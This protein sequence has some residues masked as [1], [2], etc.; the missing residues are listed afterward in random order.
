MA[1]VRNAQEIDGRRRLALHSPVD[2]RPIAEFD[3][4]DRDD[5]RN[6]VTR[7]RAAQP[8]WA[9]RDIGERAAIIG[10]AIDV[11]VARR[12]EITDTIREETGKPHAEALGVEI[13]PSCDFLNYWTKRARRDLRPHRQ[14]LHGYLRP[15]KK[16]HIQYQPLGVVAVITP[17]NAPFVLTLNPVV[18]A[19]LAGNTVVFKPSEVTPRSGE[20]VARI[21][22]EAGVPRDV[23]QALHGDGETGA[24]LVDSPVDKVCFT[25]SVGTGR[26]IAT[27]C[28]ERL[29][30]CTLELGGKDAMI[31]CADADLE[32]AAAGA[33]Y[34]SMFNTGQVCMSVERIYVIDSV[35]DEFIALVQREAAEVTC[36]AGATDMGPL[37]WDRQRDIVT[38]HVEDARTRGAR[39]L[40]GGSAVAGEGLYF[41]PTV[42]AEAN[43]DMLIMTDE[44]FGPVAAIMRVRDEDEAIRLAND[45]RYG[46]SGS[47]FTRDPATARRIAARLTTGSVVHN[48]S[49]VIYGVPEAPFG[50]RKDSG[51]GH[52]NGVHA[53]R[54]FTHA[55][56]V[57]ITR[58]RPSRESIWYPYT[59]KTIR[60]LDGLIRY[61]FGNKLL[62]RLLS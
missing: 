28:A 12:A 9:A 26:K 53:L 57:L 46:L 20:W 10:R 55:Q 50:G 8:D 40:V 59:D 29:L 15:M 60:D 3:V 2:R 19:L 11:I 32:R 24:A 39:I 36:G 5:V 16:L 18:Q 56:P 43:H 7:A 4:D 31:V 48:D 47:V 14:R 62:R 54:G 52:V 42:I 34:L 13:V 35:A 49:A 61:G 1:I 17:W 22:H 58:R 6:A 33:V 41:E 23:V 30:P 44:T 45:S 25:G 27:A 51:V 38:A 37:F 21:L